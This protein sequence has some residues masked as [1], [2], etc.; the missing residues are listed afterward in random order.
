MP[1]SEFHHRAS[2]AEHICFKLAVELESILTGTEEEEEVSAALLKARADAN[3]LKYQ[4]ETLSK[5][6][7]REK[8]GGGSG[9][10]G[11]AGPAPAKKVKKSGSGSRG[12]SPPSKAAIA[13]A[14]PTVALSVAALKVWLAANSS[15]A[16]AALTPTDPAGLTHEILLA[17]GMGKCT[18]RKSVLRQAHKI[19]L[20][21]T[22][23]IGSATPA[24]APPTAAAPPAAAP[25]ASKAP[26]PPTAAGGGGKGADILVKIDAQG[27]VVRELK[28][29]GAAKDEIKAAVGVLL[30]LKKE[31]KAVTGEDV[32]KPGAAPTA[33]APKAKKAPPPTAPV[34]AADGGCGDGA[35]ILA[36]VDAQGLVVRELKGA[37]AAKDEIKAAVGVLLGLK[38][39]YK[40]VT[41]KEVP[42]K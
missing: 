22:L 10:A 14:A 20:G 42:K 34:A 39:E 7:A 30:G 16:F 33:A 6:V 18:D 4:L 28:G 29:V 17:A 37:G 1:E 12:T 5:S 25:K 26:A 41:G 13:V 21:S 32:P 23:T 24:P 31:Y 19:A 27:L 3:K 11:G 9:G 36:K 2:S 40:V 38:K 8:G 15:A 35:A